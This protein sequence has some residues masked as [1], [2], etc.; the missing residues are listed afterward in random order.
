MK[1]F[2]KSR[3]LTVLFT[4]VGASGGFLYWKYVGCNSGTCPIRSV[5]YW[6]TLWGAAAGYLVGDL[7]GDII[8]KIKIRRE[9]KSE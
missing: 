7:I 2:I 3:Y 6:S 9:E 1:S 4:I 5:W 8:R